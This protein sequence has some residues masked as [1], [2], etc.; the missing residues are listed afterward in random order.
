[1]LCPYRASF[2]TQSF[3]Q[4]VAIGL[5]MFKPF[6]GFSRGYQLSILNSQFSK[7]PILVLIGICRCLRIGLLGLPSRAGW[8]NVDSRRDER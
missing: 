4:G 1:M 5:D 3:T 2:V 8:R 7:S 6:Q